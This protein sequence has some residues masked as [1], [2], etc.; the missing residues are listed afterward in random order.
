MRNTQICPCACMCSLQ[1]GNNLWQSEPIII[2]ISYIVIIQL[3]HII[4]ITDNRPQK[5]LYRLTNLYFRFEQAQLE[6][7]LQSLV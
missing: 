6:Q 2:M 1:I 4:S 7:E 3:Y 5:L